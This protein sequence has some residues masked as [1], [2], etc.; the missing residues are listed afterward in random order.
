MPSLAFR[1]HS[2]VVPLLLSVSAAWGQ[3]P[4]E[5]SIQ[6]PL[7]QGAAREA[8]SLCARSLA[9]S[10]LRADVGTLSSCAEVATREGDLEVA[11]AGW[12]KVSMLEPSPWVTLRIAEVQGR[13]FQLDEALESYAQALR[14]EASP[15]AE[16]RLIDFL[17]AMALFERAGTEIDAALEWA[18]EDPVLLEQGAVV[19]AAQDR[20]QDALDF[21][22]RSWDAGRDPTAWLQRPRL[23]ERATEAPYRERVDVTALVRSLDDRDGEDLLFLLRLLN[24]FGGEAVEESS[25]RL[26][27]FLSRQTDAEVLHLGLALL[28]E[29]ASPSLSKLG[30]ESL[31]EAAEPRTR[32]AALDEIARRLLSREKTSLGSGADWTIALRRALA[33]ERDPGNADLLEVLLVVSETR[34][35]SLEDAEAAVRGLSPANS[36]LHL[37]LHVLAS[38]FESAGWSRRAQQIR[39]EAR[40][41]RPVLQRRGVV[42]DD[43]RLSFWECRERTDLEEVRELLRF[44]RYVDRVDGRLYGLP[45]DDFDDQKNLSIAERVFLRAWARENGEQWAQSGPIQYPREIRHLLERIERESGTAVDCSGRLAAVEEPSIRALAEDGSEVK[46]QEDLGSDNEVHVVVNPYDPRHVVA[47]SNPYDAG[48]TGNEV[49]RSSDWGKSW[50]HGYATVANNCCD[51][52][53]YYNRTEVE[54]VETD[55]LYHSTLVW[56]GP[57]TRVLYSTDHGQTFSDCGVSI[58]G[59]RDRQDHAIDTNP[60]S[61]CHNT[62]YLAHHNGTQYV[63]ASTGDVFPYCQSWDE[64]STGVGGTLG[65]AIVVSTNGRAHNVFTQYAAPGGVY[66][67]STGDCGGSWTNAVKISEVTNAGIFEWGIPSTCSRQI[68]RYPQADSDRQTLSVYRNNIY[69]VWNDLNA[70]GTAPGCA[71]NTA[72][73]ND[74]FLAVG[75][76]DDRDDPTSWTWSVTNLTDAFTDDYTD[77]FYPSLTVDQADGSVYVSYYRSNSG[78]PGGVAN[79]GPRKSQVHYVILHSIDGGTTWETPHQI[80]DQPSDESGSGAYLAMQWGD[81]TWNDVIEGVAYAAWT[82]R[83][84]GADE[85]I[86][87]AKICSPPAHWSERAPDFMPPETAALL[88]SEMTYQVTWDLPDLYWGDGGESPASRHFELWV[89]G[90]LHTDDIP[91]GSSMVEWNAPDGEGHT[92]QIR[93]VNQCGLEKEYAAVAVQ[94]GDGLFSDDFESGTTADWSNRVP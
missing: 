47:S 67:T 1:A 2:S 36:Q 42:S 60:A 7:R 12:Q 10:W 40:D 70:D 94:A 27:R 90:A 18:G 54:S 48:A 19:A 20:H 4:D 32:R 64:Q 68:Y 6:G 14:S 17:L 34:A 50:S 77:E 59:P 58:G 24:R 78:A 46:V 72:L 21:L 15:E 22:E 51:P 13:L 92:L 93:A 39:E 5:E 75:T 52:V 38:R 11:L 82:D 66:I 45:A 84:E 16:H 9:E 86:W 57:Q 63:A 37:A 28:R 55:V 3:L 26:V 91:A 74:I 69:V 61:A 71:G 85:D 88:D 43:V 87:A 81:Y 25:V 44:H 89:D 35:L 41:F 65:S 62:V 53:S 73:N 79:V 33:H 80:T 76:P 83:R 30:L 8:S 31:L 23:V 56:P 49:Y 29:A